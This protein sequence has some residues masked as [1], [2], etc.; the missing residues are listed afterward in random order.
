M[1]GE[2]A[3]RVRTDE[4]ERRFAAGARLIAERD[5]AQSARRHVT[6]AAAR[7]HRDG[8]LVSFADI[9]DREAAAALTGS[10]LLAT[11]G[12]DERPEDDEEFYDHQLVGLTAVDERG[13]P[14]G[15][16]AEVVHLPAQD[17]LAIDLAVDQRQVLVPFVAAIVPAVDLA[18]GRVTLVPPD[19]LL[20]PAAADDAAGADGGE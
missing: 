4:P 14:L 1:H 3:V 10:W 16:V 8:L 12:A 17:L 20:D 7:P 2:V 19:G 11:V 15:T 6:V 18:A 9:A 5:G 13:A